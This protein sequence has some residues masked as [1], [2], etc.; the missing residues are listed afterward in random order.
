MSSSTNEGIFFDPHKRMQG[1]MLKNN[2]TIAFKVGVLF[3]P[4]NLGLPLL[5]VVS[6]MWTCVL[7]NNNL[8]LG[9]GGKLWWGA[10]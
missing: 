8:G 5:V 4:L 1:E 9:N 10:L 7:W 6:C 3:T 2:A